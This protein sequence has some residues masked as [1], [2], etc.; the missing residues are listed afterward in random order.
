MPGARQQYVRS[1]T[2]AWQYHSRSMPGTYK[3]HARSMPRAYERRC[4]CDY[5]GMVICML[6]VSQNMIKTLHGASFA[7]G[8]FFLAQASRKA[9]HT[10]IRTHTY[11]YTYAFEVKNRIPC[12]SLLTTR[13]L[14]AAQFWLRPVL[15]TVCLF[16]RQNCTSS[17]QALRK[18]TCL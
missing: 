5:L 18:A 14:C 1:M 9:M 10:C 11:V 16:L 13:L 2:G 12:M 15:A 6:N 8:K 17:A 7:Q 4:L 3:E